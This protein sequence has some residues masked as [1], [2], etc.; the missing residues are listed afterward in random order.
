M[1]GSFTNCT[2]NTSEELR[3]DSNQ[4]LT[5]V[6]KTFGVSSTQLLI[7]VN[8]SRSVMPYEVKKRFRKSSRIDQITTIYLHL[9]VLQY[10]STLLHARLESLDVSC[11]IGHLA[12]SRLSWSRWL[13]IQL[14]TVLLN[15]Q[16]TRSTHRGKN[17]QYA[18]SPS[19]STL[20]H[21]SR[22]IFTCSPQPCVQLSSSSEAVQACNCDQ[23]AAKLVAILPDSG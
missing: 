22:V 16:S 1:P 7:E 4:M 14:V 20:A 18:A 9:P 12:R 17:N 13:E 6:S 15:H 8:V 11:A 10:G 23:S 3:R 21:R 2:A 19:H 5:A